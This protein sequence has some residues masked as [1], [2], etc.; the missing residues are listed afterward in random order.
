MPTLRNW[1]DDT[2][3][4][5]DEERMAYLQGIHEGWMDVDNYVLELFSEWPEAWKRR[6]L[7]L[8]EW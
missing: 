8:E 1:G 2:E 4:W 5:L 6:W 3:Q 7:Y